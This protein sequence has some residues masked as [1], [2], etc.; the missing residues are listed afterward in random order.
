MTQL[1]ARL[2]IEQDTKQ[3]LLQ[4]ERRDYIAVSM[5]HRIDRE[6]T[7]IKRLI[8]EK[9]NTE[10]LPYGSNRSVYGSKEG[11]LEYGAYTNAN[12]HTVPALFKEQ[13][14]YTEGASQ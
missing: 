7:K 4:T 10:T 2:Q 14:L 6:I 9:R 5:L 3:R 1:I 8:D 11:C 12:Y 13:A